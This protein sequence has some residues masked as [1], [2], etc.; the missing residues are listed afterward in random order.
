MTPKINM[1]KLIVI[2]TCFVTTLFLA[3]SLCT[4]PIFMQ[5]MYCVKAWRAFYWVFLVC[6][7]CFSGISPS[8]AHLDFKERLSGSDMSRGG[9]ANGRKHNWRRWTFQDSE[10]TVRRTTLE[11]GE[12]PHFPTTTFTKKKAVGL[13]L[14]MGTQAAHGNCVRLKP[15]SGKS[16]VFSVNISLHT[17][18]QPSSQDF[19]F[20]LERHI[21]VYGNYFLLIICGLGVGKGWFTIK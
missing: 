2:S 14:V 20:S 6:N 21:F 7:E 13:Q 1:F 3:Y 16:F 15:F 17:I 8:Y 5:K 18:C 10:R 11:F 19:K 4:L 12:S 9:W